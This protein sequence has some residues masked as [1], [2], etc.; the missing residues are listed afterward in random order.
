MVGIVGSDRRH[1]ARQLIG[2]SARGLAIKIIMYCT[3][4]HLCSNHGKQMSLSETVSV[5]ETRDLTVKYLYVE[6][7]TDH[8]ESFRLLV[9]SLL[10]DLR[11]IVIMPHQPIRLKRC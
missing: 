10:P 11:T 4:A 7:S 8:L 1:R 9:N 5:E 6:F 3:S 2:G